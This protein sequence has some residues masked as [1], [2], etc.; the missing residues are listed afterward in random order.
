MRRCRRTIVGVLVAGLG[1]AGCGPSA[2][3]KK[4][5]DALARL[6]GG[7]KPGFVRLLNLTPD[8]ASLL[9]RGRPATGDIGAGASSKLVPF[10][11]GEREVELASGSG[12]Q[13]LMVKLSSGEGVTV[14]L[15]ASGTPL[16]VPNEPRYPLGLSNVRVVFLNADGSRATG[17]QGVAAKGVTGK[18]DLS[19][20]TEMVNLGVG[21]WEITG[22]GLAPTKVEVADKFAYTL[23]L[24]GRNGKFEPHW[25]LNTPD[26]KPVGQGQPGA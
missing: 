18:V 5:T 3:E 26:D 24:I 11:V 10:G 14:V 21:A 2:E 1:L 22:P 12:K 13:K 16:Q 15:P 8:S 7:K 23:L 9:D 6:Q 17:A 4:G 25:M 20:K 19:P